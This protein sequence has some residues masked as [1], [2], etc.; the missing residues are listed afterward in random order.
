MAF[1][2]DKVGSFRVCRDTVFD[3]HQVT[4]MVSSLTAEAAIT[5][6]T[7]VLERVKVRKR[8]S[9]V[10]I[11]VETA[12][13]AREAAEKELAELKSIFADLGPANAPFMGKARLSVPQA[14]FRLPSLSALESEVAKIEPNLPLI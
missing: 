2:V 14:E 4:E 3:R 5:S 10:K 11:K 12:K 7:L 8:L 1:S 6:T 9:K 13:K